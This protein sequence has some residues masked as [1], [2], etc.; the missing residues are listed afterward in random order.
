MNLFFWNLKGKDN[1][2]LIVEALLENDVDIAAF[3]EHLGTDFDDLVKRTKEA[4]RLVDP[5]D[6]AGKVRLLVRS[7]FHVSGIFGQRRYLMAN[8]GFGGRAPLVIAA[9]HLQDRRN[10]SD[11]VARSETVRRIVDDLRQQEIDSGSSDCVVIG[12]FNVD[13]FSG[14]LVKVTGFNATLYREVATRSS[15]RRFDG[16]DYPFLYNPTIEHICE[17]KHNCGSFYTSKGGATLYW[18]CLDQAIVSPSLASK[19]RT[20]RYLRLIGGKSLMS[21]VAPDSN[22]SDHLPL[23]VEIEMEGRDEQ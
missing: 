20:Y 12:D 13:P 23:L 9:L 11:G 18:H 15:S 17:A 5:V 4:Y 14:E 22:V 8:I 10:D 2:G 19:I 1:A 21:E 6:N 7:G 16:N 3:A